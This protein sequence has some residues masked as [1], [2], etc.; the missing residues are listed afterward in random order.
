VSFS[1][2][3]ISVAESNTSVAL[4][5][6]R[7]NGSSGTVSVRYSTVNG[8]ATSASDYGLVNATLV[9]GDGQTERTINIPLFPDV[10]VEGNETFDVVLSDPTG[11]LVVGGQ[12]RAT[13][14]IQ[15]DDFGPGS[16]DPDFNPGTGANALV[17]SVAAQSDGRIIIGGAFTQFDGYDRNYIARLNS[18]GSLD[19]GFSA[20][21]GPNGIVSAVGLDS[22]EGDVLLAGAFTSVNG[23]PRNRFARLTSGGATD[24]AQDQPTGLDAAAYALAVQT[25]SKAIV[26]GSFL[27]PKPSLTRLRVNGSPD[28]SFDTGAGANGPVFAVAMGSSGEAVAGG[29]FTTVDGTG[30]SRVARFL[31]DGALDLGFIPAAVSGGSIFAVAVQ[32]DRK[33]VIGGDFTSVGGQSRNRIARLNADGSLDTAFNPGSAA[34]GTVYGIAVQPDDK[35]V[36]VG[37]FTSVAGATRNRIARL[38]A[39]GAVDPSFDPGLGANN[40]V[41]TLALL[42]G[43]KIIIGGEFTSVNGFPR[44]GVARLNGDTSGET[45]RIRPGFGF[46]A[47]TFRLSVDAIAGRRYALDTSIDLIN[48]TPL[49]TNTA[50]GAVLD[51]IDNTPAPNRRFYRTRLAP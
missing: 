2:S 16:L 18:S 22:T 30:R 8:T 48:W 46:S 20:G 37:A 1:V 3:A 27:I 11:G 45:L 26:G 23:S 35:I 42:P 7:T 49:M 32:A 29:S 12:S 31:S 51:F 9:F 4:T 28:T 6:I 13:I 10:T 39:T 14:T 44:N 43:G 33:V 15:D 5:V 19:F 24:L 34:N 41:Y 17:R 25:D 21:A 36:M 40:I 47:N 38:S 50:S